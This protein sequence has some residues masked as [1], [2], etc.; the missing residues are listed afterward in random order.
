M[1]FAR[2]NPAHLALSGSAAR[3]DIWLPDAMHCRIDASDVLGFAQTPSFVTWAPLEDLTPETFTTSSPQPIWTIRRGTGL[4]TQVVGVSPAANINLSI[5]R[6]APIVFRLTGKAIASAEVRI[7]QSRG[8]FAGQ[9]RVFGVIETPSGALRV[10]APRQGAVYRLAGRRFDYL[11]VETPGPE[12]RLNSITGITEDGLWEP[13]V[14]QGIHR[15]DKIRH[16]L[17]FDGLF[18]KP[19]RLTQAE[20]D[21]LRADGLANFALQGTTSLAGNASVAAPMPPR[22]GPLFPPGSD[23]ARLHQA[24]ASAAISASVARQT[25]LLDGPLPQRD[26]E[27]TDQLQTQSGSIVTGRVKPLH[28]LMLAAEDVFLSTILGRRIALTLPESATGPILVS[29]RAIWKVPSNDAAALGGRLANA[30]VGT[31][32][33]LRA[34]VLTDRIDRAGQVLEKYLPGAME[35]PFLPVEA[36]I[37]IDPATLDLPPLRPEA[38]PQPVAQPVNADGDTRRVTLRATIQP[39]AALVLD[40]GATDPRTRINTLEVKGETRPDGTQVPERHKMIFGMQAPGSPSIGTASVDLHDQSAPFEETPYRLAQRDPFGRWS[41]FTGLTAPEFVRPAPPAPTLR[42]GLRRGA[43]PGGTDLLDIEVAAPHR[44]LIAPGGLP[45]ARLD[46]SV[47]IGGANNDTFDA[48]FGPLLATG[49]GLDPVR[50]SVALPPSGTIGQVR[51]ARVAAHF[52][53]TAGTPGPDAVAKRDIPDATPPPPPGPLPTLTPLSFPDANGVTRAETLVT[54]LDPSVARLRI[55]LATEASLRAGLVR[56]GADTAAILAEPDLAARAALLKALEADIPADAWAFA[57]EIPVSGRSAQISQRINGL[58]RDLV[59]LRVLSVTANDIVSD[60]G[61]IAY[62]GLPQAKPLGPP[63]VEARMLDDQGFELL[64]PRP[65]GPR[66][67]EIRLMRSADSDNPARM[68][69]SVEIAVDDTTRWPIR[70]VDRGETTLGPTA[71]LRSYTTYRWRAQSRL[72]PRFAGAAP[73]PWTLP[74]AVGRAM[75]APPERPAPPKVAISSDPALPGAVVVTLG[76]LPQ[77]RF[78]AHVVSLPET[79]PSQPTQVTDTEM[80]VV[81]PPDSNRRAIRVHVSDPLGRS[82]ETIAIDVAGVLS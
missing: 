68:L 19:Q 62:F 4:F 48:T 26:Q 31:R 63:S 52:T 10:P 33:D 57:D 81:L 61:P 58:P 65:P 25:P 12:V 39:G 71:R 7:S 22:V 15:R 78:M 30:M 67:D 24:A 3:N 38:T 21:A 34:L 53:D 54:G 69:P 66:P 9:A 37:L 70:I 23:E 16:A 44:G 56:E 51:T 28:E 29:A 40:R 14:W 80:V 75:I 74:G 76:E 11:M 42:L 77:G 55:F 13:K 79:S 17:T 8:S 59:C 43:G 32:A 45:I 64:I 36:R 50:H 1:I 60:D 18:S 41:G 27:N 2:S 82:S 72:A 73:G 47:P 6:F 5:N 46:I 49:D 35:G 20:R